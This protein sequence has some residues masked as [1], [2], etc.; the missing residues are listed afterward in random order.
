VKF[1][2][3]TAKRISLGPNKPDQREKPDKPH[4]RDKLEFPTDSHVEC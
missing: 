2:I 4:Q 3:V 1:T